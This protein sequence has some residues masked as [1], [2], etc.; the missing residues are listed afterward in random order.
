M[1]YGCL[2][3]GTRQG[4][5]SRRKND[6]AARAVMVLLAVATSVGLPASPAKA[7]PPRQVVAAGNNAY[8]QLGNG[9]APKTGHVF[10]PVSV[11]WYASQISGGGLSAYA[12]TLYNPGRVWAWGRN[13]SGQLGDGTTTDRPLPVL[14]P[15]LD[16]AQQVAGGGATAYA[17]LSDGTV[18]AWGRG[19]SGQLG[20]GARTDSFVPV[21][22]HGLTGVTAIAGGGSAGYA[23]R[24]DGTVW[25]WGNNAYGQLGDGT[26]TNTATPVQVAGLTGVTAI[27]GGRWA[28]YALR[29]DGTVRAWGANWH[30]QLGNGG[31]TNQTTPVPVVGLSR[32]PLSTV[33]TVTGGG[34]FAYALLGDGTVAAWGRGD[35][36]QL[37]NGSPADSRVAR[38]VP[39]LTAVAAIAAGGEAG[40]A[41]RQDGPEPGA[42]GN[43][44]IWAWGSN[45]HGQLGIDQP[46]AHRAANLF[47]P[48][49]VPGPR[50]VQDIAAGGYSAYAIFQPS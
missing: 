47:R 19:G 11:I 37:G 26:T 31:R 46:P 15:G 6:W 13:E 16:G 8:G 20:N 35:L 3:R 43:R 33:R 5:D 30:G 1:R 28:G 9:Q 48:R 32:T 17:L 21:R 18:W 39:G 41:L 7:Y 4:E 14:V 2:R 23:R 40:Y 22:V 38:P 25:A 44:V 12:L 36:G 34:D 27:S 24:S 10:G 29:A 42:Y 45:A 50:D 49:Q